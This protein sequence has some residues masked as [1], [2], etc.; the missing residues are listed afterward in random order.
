MATLTQISELEK[1]KTTPEEREVNQLLELV[2][3]K[4]FTPVALL[5]IIEVPGDR[6][7]F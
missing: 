3:R 4:L 7:F 6:Q 1:L 2:T 5:S